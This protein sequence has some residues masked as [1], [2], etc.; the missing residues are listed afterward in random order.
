MTRK[1]RTLPLHASP[2]LFLGKEHEGA[3]PRHSLTF[4]GL[5]CSKLKKLP[6][7]GPALVPPTHRP[8]LEAPKHPE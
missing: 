5:A 8:V 2:D 7:E 1:P 4:E 3:G 6:K